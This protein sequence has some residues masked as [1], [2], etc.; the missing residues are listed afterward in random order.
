M[1][2][3]QHFEKFAAECERLARKQVYPRDRKALLLM[4]E[5][6]LLLAEHAF[7]RRS[8]GKSRRTIE[9]RLA[10]GLVFAR[11]RAQ[12]Q[13]IPRACFVWAG[14]VSSI[15][16]LDVFVRHLHELHSK[17]SDRHSPG[18]APETALPAFGEIQLGP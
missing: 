18:R 1:S 17:F 10:G 13:A 7:G 9:R 11:P 3:T 6:W 2:D 5:A 12:S 14:E 15:H 16:Q 4:A 8:T